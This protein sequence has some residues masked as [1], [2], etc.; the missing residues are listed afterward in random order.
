MISEVVPVFSRKPLY[1]RGT[2]IVSVTIIGLLGFMVWAHHMFAVGLPTYFDTIM[3]ATSMLIAIPTGVKIFNWLATMWGGALRFKPP[4][5]FACGMI[6]FFTIGGITGVTVAVV[7][8]DWQ[9]T[10][11]YYIV[12]H[13]HNVLFAG[14]VFAVL[15]GF[16]YWFPKMTGRLLS[17]RLGTVHFWVVLV[18]F[19]LT[20]LPMYALGVMG[21]PRRVYTYAP[22]VGWNVLNYVSSVGGFIIG[23]SILIWLANVI[24]SLRA[25]KRAGDDPWDAWTLEWATTSPPP[26]ENFAAL[27]V[28][29]SERPLWD[30]KQARRAGAPG[31]EATAPG[32]PA[33][34]H[35]AAMVHAPAPEPLA[36]TPLPAVLAVAVAI[37]AAGLVGAP[38][39]VVV[40]AAAVL[41]IMYAWMV[42]RWPEAE[43]P[44]DPGQRFTPVPLGMLVFLGSEIVLFGSLIY[45]YIDARYRLMGWPPPG[46][47]HLDVTL[48]ALNT[49]VLIAS[50]ITMEIALIR[51]RRGDFRRFRIFLIVTIVLGALFLTG[52][53]WEYLHVGFGLSGGIMAS[54]FFVL[55]GLHGAHVTAGLLVLFYAL[56]N[57]ERRRRSH[58]GG[59]ASSGIDMLQA[60]TYYWH[61]VDVVWV[62]LFIILY[63]F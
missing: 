47:P 22:D 52:Q 6:A 32:A 39:A 25:G 28:I 58:P 53:A 29:T 62:V 23:V 35:G 50:G 31:P 37:V 26:P 16:Y 27:P 55:T 11:T 54:T 17:D 18:G 1:G 46:M 42:A 12:G 10:D 9:V 48:P 7:P 24:V 8:F 2:M 60:G 5:L 19:G 38:A 56:L 44:L 49:D 30:L 34:Q 3:A 57:V 36:A 20:F 40:G 21:M 63:L 45:A 61:F 51:F 59:G 13:L 33:S 14:T 4:L 43:A 15:G 41:A